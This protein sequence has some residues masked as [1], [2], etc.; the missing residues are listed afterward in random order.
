[1]RLDIGQITH[2]ILR[3]GNRRRIQL[4][5]VRNRLNTLNHIR[6]LI[7]IG[8]NNLV[9]CLLVQIREL[10]EHLLRSVQ[11]QRRLQIRILVALTCLQNRT[12]LCILRIKE[13]HVAGCH[14]QLAQALAQ[15][16]DFAVMLAQ[17]LFGAIVFPHQEL[18]IARRLDFQIIIEAGDFLQLLIA[19]T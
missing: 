19:R 17:I 9:G 18:V 10:L 3:T 14:S 5:A 2:G 16:I 11:V 8:N 6:N 15:L 13:M 4:V 12:Q 7:G 1:M